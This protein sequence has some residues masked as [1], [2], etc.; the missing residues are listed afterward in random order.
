M[1]NHITD[2]IIIT[3]YR[4]SLLNSSLIFVVLS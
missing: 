2:H 4:Y 1:I 3:H